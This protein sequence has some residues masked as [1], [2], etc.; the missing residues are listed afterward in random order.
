[1]KKICIITKDSRRELIALLSLQQTCL[2]AP[3]YQHPKTL[4]EN[5]NLS[6]G[7]RYFDSLHLYSI[8]FN[9]VDDFHFYSIAICLD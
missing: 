1:M 4:E 2:S 7:P 5:I 8:S 9:I 6:Q 3:S